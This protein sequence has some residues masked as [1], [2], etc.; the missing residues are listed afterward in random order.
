LVNFLQGYNLHLGIG[1]QRS[2]ACPNEVRKFADAS[3]TMSD[4]YLFDWQ[5]KTY[6]FICDPRP[7]TP[8]RHWTQWPK[9]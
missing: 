5:I 7:S 8:A 6:V 1:E 4:P 3:V 2:G 9:G